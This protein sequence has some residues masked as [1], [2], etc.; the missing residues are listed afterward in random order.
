MTDQKRMD[1]L[2][3][4]N[5][6]QLRERAEGREVLNM[7]E[8]AALLGFRDSRTV[9]RLFPFSHGYI[10]IATLARCLTPNLLPESKTADGE[11]EQYEK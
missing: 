11:V 4:D 3:Q 2:Y 10:S 7:R 9:K 6:T 1:I 5:L 8:T